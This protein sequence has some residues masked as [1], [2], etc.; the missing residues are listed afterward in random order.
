MSKIIDEQDLSSYNANLTGGA[1]TTVVE[2]VNRYIERQTGRCFGEIKT[3]TERYD[4]KNLIW[5]RKMD[6]TE[7]TSIYL[8]F[9]GQT[10]QL[11]PASGYFFN[12]L[13]RITMYYTSR[14]GDSRFSNDLLEITYKYGYHDDAYANDG[15]TPLVPA[16]LKHA[17][18]QLAAG[19]WNYASNQG[20][21]VVS[22]SIDS[23][24]LEF[25]DKVR[26]SNPDPNAKPADNP[27]SVIQSYALRRA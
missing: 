2:A 18:I 19:F 16:D 1:A 7:I 8:G 9:P 12:G 17:A 15:I 21:E 20:R 11:V 3:I 5:L 6:V 4:Y 27:F 13:G 26:T 24:Q 14:N 25:A 22:A 23:Y 10:Q